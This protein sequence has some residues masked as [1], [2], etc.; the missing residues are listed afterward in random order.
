[1]EEKEPLVSIIIL[2]YN[3]G[4][5]LRNCVKSIFD[6]DYKNLEIIVVDNISNDNSHILCKEEFQKI[7]LIEN[8]ENLGYCEGNNIGIRKANGKFI[9]IINP[10]TEVSSTWLH[11]LLNAQK[12]LGEG[13]FQPKILSL[14]EK[15]ILQSTG[16]MIHLFGIGFSRDLG[17]IDS[18]KHD[19]VERVGYAA[20]TCFFTSSEVF[21][22]VG[23]FDPF[24]F[25]YHDDLDF[26]WRAAQIGIKSFYIPTSKIFHVKSYNLKWSSKKFFWLERNR[27]YCILTHYSKDTISKMK[28][29]LIF[30][31]IIIWIAYLS[32][33]FLVAKIK[34]D[35]DILRNKDHIRKKYAELEKKKIIDDQQLIK[36]F[37]DF[38]FLSNNISQNWVSQ[39]FNKFI[40]KLSKN[41]KQKIQN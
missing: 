15:N 36:I 9:V 6:S 1:M 23:L 38:V 30:S 12:K 11:E 32:K 28:L 5:L 26:G 19:K 18:G 21:K 16:N 34:A 8:K 3:A 2:N 40:M 24:I 14:K 13:I 39:I 7:K 31:E 25:L 22:K 10:D 27:K 35:L 17:I 29:E 4:K 37:P 33:G 20:G 41:A